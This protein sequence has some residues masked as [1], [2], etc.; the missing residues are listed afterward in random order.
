VA[1]DK[2]DDALPILRK[3]LEKR[4]NSAEA[5]HY[6]GRA[7]FARSSSSTG[8]AMRFLKRATELDPNHAEYHLFVAWAANESN[9]REALGLARDEVDKAFALDK[10]NGDVFW[11]RGVLERK[12]GAV[13]DA[14]KDLRRA[15]Q[16]KPSRIEA[17][18][19]L[20][21]CLED[22]NEVDAALA[23]WQ[24]AVA[25][26]GRVPAWRYR[27]GKLL[28]ERGD[29]ADA[30]KHLSFAVENTEKVDVRPGWYADLQF[31]A[32]EALRKSG[33][34]KDAILRY[35]RFLEVAPASSPDRRDAVRAIAQ[36]GGGASQGD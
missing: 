7:L 22:K 6:L 16:L 35:Q 2:P 25:G 19:A 8:E 26:N 12:Q 21:E 33:R 13:V 10:L 24:R 1:V 34:G 17:H 27:Y 9:S 4:A 3:V 28:L 5:N 31:Q 18:A 30:V 36:L 29:A 11:Q 23:E 32:A 15:L 20:A 14:V